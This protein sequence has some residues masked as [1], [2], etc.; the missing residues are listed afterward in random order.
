MHLQILD[1]DGSVSAQ[2]T[3]PGVLAW[4]SVSTVPLRDLGARLRLWS[5][6]AT[7]AQARARIAADARPGASVSLLGSGDYHH[8][9]V[10]LME[11]AREPIT[12]IHIDNHPDWARL[13]PRWHC[14]SWVNQAL[15][16][17][18][19]A[20]VITLGPCSDDLV[21]PELKGGNLKALA[22]ARI[23]LFP[24]QHA[25]SRVWRKIA[26]GPGHHYVDGH[27]IWRNLAE[28][29]VEQG[30]AVIIA[31][32]PTQAIWLSIDKDVLPESQA[33]TNWD[34]GQMP[35]ASVLQVI[36][37]IGA[38][39]RIVGADICGEFSLSHHRNPFKRWE[40]RMD[41]PQR[42]VDTMLLAR[43]EQTNGELLMAIERASRAYGSNHR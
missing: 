41:Q 31:Q 13:A 29:G 38:C 28:T 21:R 27:L 32:I 14:G 8:L 12:I 3:L 6:N 35:L 24:W 20:K 37:A 34:Q 23:N 9:A 18:Q 43:N 15:R 26:D 30:L 16:L 39:K 10:L 17:P 22:A 36:S 1:L 7:M 11:Q 2:R 40:A 4:T 33:L 42:E 19:V 25:P 5:R